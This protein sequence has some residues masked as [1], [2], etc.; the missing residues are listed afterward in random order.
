MAGPHGRSFTDIIRADGLS[1]KV[2]RRKGSRHGIEFICR[3][4][5]NGPGVHSSKGQQPFLVP[6]D[7]DGADVGHSLKREVGFF[8]DR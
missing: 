2:R 1:D 5:A 7:I 4:E 8:K 3:K 6:F